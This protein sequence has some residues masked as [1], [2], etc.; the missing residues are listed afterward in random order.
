VNTPGA[1]QFILLALAAYRVYRLIAEDT[2]LDRPRRWLVRLGS[3]W[4]T[5][6]DPVP[7]AYRTKFAAFITCPWCCGAHVSWV[8]WLCW[9]WEPHWTLVLC[10]PFALS[11]VVGLTAKN[12]DRE[13]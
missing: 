10:T 12:L 13:E 2:I 5:E 7:K 8:I 1:W 9:Q 11:A 3:D 4:Q 6:G